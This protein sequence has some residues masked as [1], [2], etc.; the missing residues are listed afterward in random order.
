ML[1]LLSPPSIGTH[2]SGMVMLPISVLVHGPQ[3]FSS[4]LRKASSFAIAKLQFA[5]NTRAH[6]PLAGPPGPSYPFTQSPL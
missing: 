1:V 2:T 3:I 4:P 6:V 5:P